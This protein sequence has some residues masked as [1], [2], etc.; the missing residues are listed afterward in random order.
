MDLVVGYQHGHQVGHCL[1]S[2]PD[3]RLVE[4]KY[5]RPRCAAAQ[6]ARPPTAEFDR[7]EVWNESWARVLSVFPITTGAPR[8]EFRSSINQ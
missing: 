6:S 2:R 3:R 8:H 7:D 4:W 5:G 1:R